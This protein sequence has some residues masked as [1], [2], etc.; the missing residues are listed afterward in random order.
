MTET[1]QEAL[2]DTSGAIRR[3]VESE[4]V[5]R[6]DDLA[7]LEASVHEKMMALEV[8]QAELLEEKQNATNLV[9]AAQQKTLEADQFRSKLLEM[10]GRIHAV[11]LAYQRK[12]E[13]TDLQI[14][15][16]ASGAR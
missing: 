11:L 16:L 6:P 1:R 9:Q 4:Y 15:D 5:R 14:D 8:R 2:T 13:F 7:T 12:I 3:E 10:E